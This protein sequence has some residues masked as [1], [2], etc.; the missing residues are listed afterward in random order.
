MSV[1][2]GQLPPDAEN[3]SDDA[4]SEQPAG[5]Q[6]ELNAWWAWVQQATEAGSTFALLVQAELRLA[7]R[8]ATGLAVIV[9]LMLPLALL[10]WVGLSVVVGWLAYAASDSVLLGLLGFTLWQV[11]V[12]ALLVRKAKVLQRRMQL[13]ATR[14]QLKSF[15]QGA[16]SD[17]H[18]SVDRQG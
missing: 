14:E 4:A 13:P 1:P 7:L 10:A 6:H 15:M 5:V 18:A 3:A 17:E 8:S 9:L 12:M 2:P 16:T 11:V